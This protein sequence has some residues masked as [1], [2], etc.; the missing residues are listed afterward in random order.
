MEP[1]ADRQ[2]G[3]LVGD[4]ECRGDPTVVL[5]A[6]L[7]AV[8]ACHTHGVAALLGEAGVVGDPV[9]D[10]LMALDGRENELAHDLKHRLIAPPGLGDQMVERLVGRRHALRRRA[11]RP[12]L[13]ALARTRQQQAG[14]V[15]AG[16]RAPVGVA[17]H[18]GDRVQTGVEPPL[19]GAVE[20]SMRLSH[21]PHMG[22]A[23]DTVRLVV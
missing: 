13:D 5:P 20:I 6:E 4:R 7:A 22:N 14:T 21:L 1:V 8:P 9:A 23:Y 12:G 10:R 18:A 16:R 3:V 11:R 17:E 2:A 15:G 19:G